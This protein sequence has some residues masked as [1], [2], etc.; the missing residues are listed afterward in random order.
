MGKTFK[1]WRRKIGVLTLLLA[2]VFAMGWIRGIRARDLID[3]GRYIPGSR[4]L[5][6]DSNGNSLT[7]MTRSG[8]AICFEN[9]EINTILPVSNASVDCNTIIKT[10]YWSIVAPVALISA[11]LLLSKPRQSKTGSTPR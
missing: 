1:P 11:W 7:V 6:I 3:T 2:C 10:P 4:G 9:G 8:D 5:V